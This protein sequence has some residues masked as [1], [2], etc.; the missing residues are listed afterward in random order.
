[1]DK[2]TFVPCPFLNLTSSFRPI[3]SIL[4]WSK[5]HGRPEREK[6]K[7]DIEQWAWNSYKTLEYDNVQPPPEEGHGKR[8]NTDGTGRGS[9]KEEVFMEWV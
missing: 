4:A 6:S 1:M 7:A 5:C 2:L 8:K 3:C 9:G